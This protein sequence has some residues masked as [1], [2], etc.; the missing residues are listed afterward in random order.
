LAKIPAFSATSTG[1]RFPEP[2]ARFP[3]A[4]RRR[5]RGPGQAVGLRGAIEE[6]PVS[7]TR[8]LVIT[9]VALDQLYRA[10]AAGKYRPDHQLF[11][12]TS[13]RYI[14]Y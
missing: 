14:T 6:G 4:Q 9:G 5:G 10:S 3:K 2:K 7:V 8:I 13:R 1:P 11:E 12:P